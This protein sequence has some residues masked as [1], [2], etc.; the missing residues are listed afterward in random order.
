MGGMTFIARIARACMA[1]VAVLAM[2]ALAACSKD[3]DPAHLEIVG[4]D[5]VRHAFNIEL[6]V[7]PEERERGLMFRQSIAADGGMLFDFKADQMV[8]MWM[9]NTYIPLDMLFIESDGTIARIAA[10][11]VPQSLETISSG[12]PVRAVL[13]IKGGE[14]A[15]QRIAAGARVIY[16]LFGK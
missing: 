11:T 2:L 10:D 7:K 6:A 5:G 8:E 3:S 4:T 16:P 9:K 13:E 14:A 15:R 12:R 1:S